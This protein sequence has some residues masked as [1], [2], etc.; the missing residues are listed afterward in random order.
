MLEITYLSK[1]QLY[2]TPTGSKP[3]KRLTRFTLWKDTASG[4]KVQK[5]NAEVIDEIIEI[6]KDRDLP[7]YY[8]LITALL[9]I[10]GW[11]INSKKVYRLEKENGLLAK[12]RK[13]K[14]RNF[15]KFR[16]AIPLR[17]LHILEMDIKYVWISGKNRFGYILTIIDTMTRYVLCELPPNC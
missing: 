17:P 12:A 1:H 13:K 14:G 15:V 5:P 3:G 8:K 11:Y 6:R 7:N 2:Y 4:T 9:Q 10:R 16:R